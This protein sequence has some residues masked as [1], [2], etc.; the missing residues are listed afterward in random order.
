MDF[1]LADGKGF[2]QGDIEGWGLLLGGESPP[3]CAWEESA[4]FLF[5][6]TVPVNICVWILAGLTCVISFWWLT[7][8]ETQR[9]RLGDKCSLFSPSGSTI[10]VLPWEATHRDLALTSRICS[11]LATF[12]SPR[13]A[14]V[15][16][17]ETVFISESGALLVEYLACQKTLV[18]HKLDTMT[19]T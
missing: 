3:Q 16:A 10:R 7:M 17:V 13:I 8:I 11:W 5:A 18:P 6:R 9:N 14:C 12:A 4:V 15:W 2:Q 19:Q 1:A